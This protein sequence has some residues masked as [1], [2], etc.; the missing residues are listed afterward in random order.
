MPTQNRLLDSLP[1][2]DRQRLL[3]ACEPAALEKG[4]LLAQRGRPLRQAY[5]P[6]A[7]A[8]SLTIHADGHQALEVGMVGCEGMLG[9]HWLLG[10][11]VAPA[12]AEV[13]IAGRAWR[14][15]RPAFSRQLAL[16]TA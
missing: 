1:R 2:A 14:I 15:G 5:F 7:G 10:P 3:G 11:G 4:Q 16:S 6:L 8:I 9:S 12:Q 13:L